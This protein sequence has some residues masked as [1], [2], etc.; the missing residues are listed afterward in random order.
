MPAV[1][2]GITKRVTQGEAPA[3]L[4]NNAL[5]LYA[6]KDLSEIPTRF[7]G[8]AYRDCAIVTFSSVNV[9]LECRWD[10]SSQNSGGGTI[11][12]PCRTMRQFYIRRQ[13]CDSNSVEWHTIQGVC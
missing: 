12:S 5:K 2:A 3:Y 6:Q 4:H 8:A 11:P 1:N 7:N 13:G 9:Y 10:H